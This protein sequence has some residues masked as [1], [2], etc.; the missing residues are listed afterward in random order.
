MYLL[1]IVIIV[2]NNHYIDILPYMHKAHMQCN[3]ILI[4]FYMYCIF[5]SIIFSFEVMTMT[6]TLVIA[7]LRTTYM[8]MR[9]RGLYIAQSDIY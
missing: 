8:T 1:S 2:D 6:L 9:L 7:A 5:V 3:L 4:Q